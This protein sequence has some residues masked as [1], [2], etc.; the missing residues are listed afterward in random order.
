MNMSTTVSKIAEV[1][2]MTNRA[3]CESIGDF[4]QPSWGNAPDWQKDSAVKGV[5]FH[6]DNPDAGPSASH[7]SW[8]REKEADGWKCGDIKD[9]DKKEH[10]CF[11]PYDKLP[12]SQQVK[13]SLFTSV[14]RSMKVLL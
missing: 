11:V 1:A 7:E 13:D 14:V 12:V 10:P 6:L 5:Q 8:L 3:Y 2:H 9:A 4:S